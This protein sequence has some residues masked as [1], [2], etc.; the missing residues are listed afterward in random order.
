MR[1][2]ERLELVG[3]NHRMMIKNNCKN[4]FPNTFDEKKMDKEGEN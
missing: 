1:E 4:F 3:Q 2:R